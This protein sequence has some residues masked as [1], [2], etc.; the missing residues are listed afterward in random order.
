[1]DYSKTFA[2]VPETPEGQRIRRRSTRRSTM[3]ASNL[4]RSSIL[5]Q[6]DGTPQTQNSEEIDGDG[7]KITMINESPFSTPGLSLTKKTAELDISGSLTKKNYH[8]VFTKQTKTR[9]SESRFEEYVPATQD[10][11]GSMTPKSKVQ[12]WLVNDIQ[13]ESPLRKRRRQSVKSLSKF[14]LDNNSSTEDFEAELTKITR[15]K[16]KVTEK[17]DDNNSSTDD[18]EAELAKIAAKNGENN[19]S[20]NDFEAELARIT[21]K[22]FN[23]SFELAKIAQDKQKDISM[24]STQSSSGTNKLIKEKVDEIIDNLDDTNEEHVPYR[25]PSFQDYSTDSAK[26]LMAKYENKGSLTPQPESVRSRRISGR[27]TIRRTR[28]LSE[29]RTSEEIKEVP[30]EKILENVCAFVEVRSKNENRSDVV[31]DQL[32]AMGA[33]VVPRIVNKC[34]H[35]VFKEGSLATYNKAKKLGLSIVSVN[36]VEACKKAKSIV[37]ESLYPP[38]NQDKYDS[39]GLFPKL[40]KTKSLQ[41]KTDEEFSKI[42]EAK[43]KR[44][45]KKKLAESPVIQE[46]PRSSTKVPRRRRSKILTTLKEYEEEFEKASPE[47]PGSPCSSEDLNTP[48]LK[49]IAKKLF[50]ANQA[51][52]STESPTTKVIKAMELEISNDSLHEEDENNRPN[53]KNS[54]N[55]QTAVGL[56]LEF[57]SPR[58]EKAKKVAIQPPP[59]KPFEEV[60]KS[61]I[62][63]QPSPKQRPTKSKVLKRRTIDFTA[64]N[65]RKM[66][67]F[68][69]LCSPPPQA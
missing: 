60:K 4:A 21:A 12:A 44:L 64:A 51:S 13:P 45:L 67:D 56:H 23:S 37:S 1:M 54:N 41:P 5:R 61:L 10:P 65:N 18:F 49:R 7:K 20:T 28:S 55:S 31:I 25:P 36:W 17:K 19:S 16:Q 62:L 48:L 35:V 47:P 66:T 9:R 26:A 32:I 8:P 11:R 57:D 38:M 68:F 58:T 33:S 39:P 43:T 34:T 63:Q 59:K 29:P 40:R 6:I 46:S 50:K 22:Q 52:P 27:V 53:E 15:D 30:M 3:V 14:L 69:G 24:F 2:V 42:I